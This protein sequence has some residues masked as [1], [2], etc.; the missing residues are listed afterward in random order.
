MSYERLKNS[1]AEQ[2]FWGSFSQGGSLGR[3]PQ[4]GHLRPGAIFSN[5][6]AETFIAKSITAVGS[7]FLSIAADEF[8]LNPAQVDARREDKTR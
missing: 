6:A 1:G 2:M 7:R 8:T 4:R 5:G 3:A